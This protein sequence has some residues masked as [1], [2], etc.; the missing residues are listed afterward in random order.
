M[1]NNNN[2][3]PKVKAEKTDLGIYCHRRSTL[4]ILSLNDSIKR[5]FIDVLD[6]KS[7]IEYMN[8]IDVL[9]KLNA[10]R[11]SEPKEEKEEERT[12][13]DDFSKRCYV[14][15]E[16]SDD[17][18]KVS[19]TDVILYY[20]IS[21]GFHKE[22]L[23]IAR[24]LLSNNIDLKGSINGEEKTMSIYD[25]FVG[26]DDKIDDETVSKLKSTNI[27]PLRIIRMIEGVFFLTWSPEYEARVYLKKDS[28][29]LDICFVA[30]DSISM[31]SVERLKESDGTSEL[32]EFNTLFYFL[33]V[34]QVSHITNHVYKELKRIIEQNDNDW[35]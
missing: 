10:L 6:I 17:Y 4:G 18:V 29:L 11:F 27:T 1:S 15:I 25:A 3:E 8:D 12:P 35:I 7:S 33:H 30:S 5:L 32:P 9:G 31:T 28:V 20:Y 22:K 2:E 23:G 21:N 24:S 16:G 14:D 19:L 34:K 13:N 26:E